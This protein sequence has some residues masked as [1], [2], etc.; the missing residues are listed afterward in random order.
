MA[1]RKHRWFHMQ[2]FCLTMN[3]VGP[4]QGNMGNA[5]KYR[6]ILGY[7]FHFLGNQHGAWE[8]RA[9]CR[10]K[11]ECCWLKWTLSQEK[12]RFST[13]TTEMVKCELVSPK[14][15]KDIYEK[16]RKPVLPMGVSTLYE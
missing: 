1:Q 5:W 3:W 9:W 13:I 16:I 12:L 14:V 10:A 11:A 2:S 6:E 15:I 4:K 8:I 7:I